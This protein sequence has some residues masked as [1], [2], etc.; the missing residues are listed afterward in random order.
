MSDFFNKAREKAMKVGSFAADK[1]GSAA[2]IGKYKA[3][4]AGQKN[5]IS[6]AEKE[7]GKIVFRDYEEGN[8]QSAEMLEL[9]EKIKAARDTISQY[10]EEIDKIKSE[11]AVE[12]LNNDN[13]DQE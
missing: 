9:C 6:S 5:D 13:N 11:G 7:L 2:E 1:A 4:I 3:K 8:N 12:T 10:E